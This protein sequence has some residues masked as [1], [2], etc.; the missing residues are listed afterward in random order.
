MV[1][2]SDALLALGYP[3]GPRA[4]EGK[5]V[6]MDGVI[7]HWP[8]ELGQQP[9]GEELA[10]VT[11]EQVEATYRELL[12]DASVSDMDA[13]HVGRT[14]DRAI[15]QVVHKITRQRDEWI[16]AWAAKF[17]SGPQR[18]DSPPPATPTPAQI[19]AFIVAAIES[20]EA[21]PP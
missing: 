16:A 17:T 4:G 11:P 12:Q 3:V 13:P 14:I 21:D 9:S 5:A 1:S 18:P 8:P 7:I 10:A 20:G 2:T 15:L 19:R 6:V